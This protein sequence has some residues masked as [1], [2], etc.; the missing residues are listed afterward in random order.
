[1]GLVCV[2]D[3]ASL[4]YSPAAVRGIAG[5]HQ[6]AN[7]DMYLHVPWISTALAGL[8]LVAPALTLQKFLWKFSVIYVV[9]TVPLTGR[10]VRRGAASRLLRPRPT[11]YPYILSPYRVTSCRL[12]G[13]LRSYCTCGGVILPR[14]YGSGD[15]GKRGWAELNSSRKKP[16]PT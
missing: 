13:T 7:S 8:Q 1:M 14:L 4:K 5:S 2:F 6:G 10:R 12:Q 11:F 16:W 3:G 15:G 9:L